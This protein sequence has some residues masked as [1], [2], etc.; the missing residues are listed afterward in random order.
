MP[1]SEPPSIGILARD[2]LIAP[3]SA[4]ELALRMEAAGLLARTISPIDRRRRELTLTPKASRLLAKLTDAHLREL[5]NLQTT[6]A[7]ALRRML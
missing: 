2:L 4:A 5:A 1:G 7:R 3:H 6:L